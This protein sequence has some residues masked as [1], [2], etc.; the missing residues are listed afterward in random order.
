VCGASCPAKRLAKEAQK[1][2]TKLKA[3][4]AALLI[5]MV[6]AAAYA[7]IL[8]T[9]TVNNT[10]N[11]IAIGIG[12]FSDAACTQPLTEIAWGDIPR[13]GQK[14]FNFWVRSESGNTDTIYISW[15]TTGLP[16]GFNL[17]ATA[18]NNPWNQAPGYR[19]LGVAQ[20]F[21]C[22][23]ILAVQNDAP[24]QAYNWYTHFTASTTP[25]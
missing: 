13:G 8:N 3:S 19:T 17:T 12:V 25:P 9:I 18:N 20:V 10:C 1:T 4:L 15:N 6:A 23:F 24:C 2:K 14:T 5:C 16:L 21:A 7:A 11:V 22:E